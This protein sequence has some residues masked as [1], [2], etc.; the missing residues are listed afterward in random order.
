MPLKTCIP[1]E[2]MTD[3]HSNGAVKTAPLFYPGLHIFPAILKT[4]SSLSN[5]IEKFF[6]IKREYEQI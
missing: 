1:P 3:E 4:R 5:Y 6:I 2:G